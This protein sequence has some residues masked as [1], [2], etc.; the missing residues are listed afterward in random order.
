LCSDCLAPQLQSADD[1]EDQATSKGELMTIGLLAT[2]RP[3]SRPPRISDS[4]Q[5]LEKA[6]QAALLASGYRA[7]AI[8]ECTVIDGEIM[9][10][11]VVSSY[12]LKQIAQESV[13]QLKTVQ[14]VHNSVRV[15]PRKDY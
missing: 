14:R 3:M 5:E 2:E 13:L 10:S 4:D 7:V 1:H 12:F 8:L 15:K 9:L 6:A 11:G